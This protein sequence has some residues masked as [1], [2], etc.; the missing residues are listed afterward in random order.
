VLA[1]EPRGSAV[2]TA[3]LDKDGQKA[4]RESFP[5]LKHRVMA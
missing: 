4:T 5:A 3:A 2:I 1:R